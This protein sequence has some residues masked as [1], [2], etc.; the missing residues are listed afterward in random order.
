VTLL[1]FLRR[2]RGLTQGELGDLAGCARGSIANLER[3][4]WA[5]PSDDFLRRLA[6]AL[7]IDPE[8]A[9]SL[10]TDAIVAGAASNAV[11]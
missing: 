3:G 10:T 4:H 11:I 7:D 8:D 9:Q 5:R 6:A 2:D 1:E